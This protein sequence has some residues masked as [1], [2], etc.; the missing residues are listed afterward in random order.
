MLSSTHALRNKSILYGI[1]VSCGPNNNACIWEVADGAG[2]DVTHS[3]KPNE[4]LTRTDE[5][6]LIRVADL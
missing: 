4:E 3:F 5:T 6:V 2:E 1:C